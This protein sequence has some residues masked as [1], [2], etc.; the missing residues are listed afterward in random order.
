MHGEIHFNDYEEFSL[1]RKENAVS[2]FYVALHE[3]G[4]A[5]GLLHSEKPDAVMHAQ[6]VSATGFT[7]T[8]LDPDDLYAV[9][10]QYPGKL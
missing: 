10:T 4:H 3:L 2:M 8:Q 6:Y 7:T 5:V 1:I 9:T